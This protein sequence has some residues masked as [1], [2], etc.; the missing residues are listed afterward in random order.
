MNT[1]AARKTGDR[2]VVE[3]VNKM[4]PPPAPPKDR[5]YEPASEPRERTLMVTPNSNPS[6]AQES[7][8][9]AGEPTI[10][11]VHSQHPP[12]P[13][14]PTGTRPK[15]PFQDSAQPERQRDQTPAVFKPLNSTPEPTACPAP[16]AQPSESSHSA[17]DAPQTA[18]KPPLGPDVVQ[19][20]GLFQGTTAAETPRPPLI[21]DFPHWSKDLTIE[22]LTITCEKPSTVVLS[23]QRDL[24]AIGAWGEQLVHSFLSH[25]RDSSA[26]GRPSVVDWCN[27]S[28]ETGQPY[29]FKLSFGPDDDSQ[30]V[31]VEVKSTVKSEKAFIHMSA[32]ELDFALKKK[33]H[34]HVF[35]V[36]NAGDAQNV[37]LCRIQNLA[38]HLHTKKLDMYIFV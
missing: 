5:V 30:S 6:S 34:Y 17:T 16:T 12:A 20:S 35:R 22:D 32:N 37:R 9:R 31:Y 36:Y 3:A 14:P 21:M 11:R 7:Q 33:E 13:A 24:A 26:P 15:E 28:G 1:E 29:D 23:D 4:W 19:V 27:E 25:W 38:Q 2:S 10:Q 18:D 8:A